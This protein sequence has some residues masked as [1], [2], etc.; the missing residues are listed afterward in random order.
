M[1]VRILAAAL[2]AIFCVAS[3]FPAHA[4]MFGKDETIHF[5]QDVKITGPKGE[6]LYLGYMTAIQYFLAGLYVKDEGYV[7]GVTGKNKS[8][9]NMPKGDKL[10]SLQKRGLIPDPLPKYS[11]GVI[12]YLLG[13]SLWIVIVVLGLWQLFSF[14]RKQRAA[15]S[16]S[17]P[18][19]S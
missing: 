17:G 15:E 9:F 12:D 4:A 6:K 3:A 7:L 18:P 13:Y 8:Y 10:K 19:S 2:V 16:A 5:I 1:K 11:L 14:L